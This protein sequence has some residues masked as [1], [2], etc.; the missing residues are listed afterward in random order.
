MQPADLSAAEQLIWHAFANGTWVDLR[1]GDPRLDDPRTA[2]RWPAS[3]TVRAK[4]IAALLLGAIEPEPGHLPAVRLRGVRITG[5]LDLMGATISCSLVCEYCQFDDAPRLTEAVTR[6]VRIVDSALPGLNAARLRADGIINLHRSVVRG[7][8]ILDRARVTGELFLRNVT[9]G[10]IPARADQSPGAG[11]AAGVALAAD[12]LVVDGDVDI[13]GATC[14]G[15]VR[16]R[17]AR[18]SGWMNASG[19]RF[20][21]AD[22]PALDAD[23]AVIGGSFTGRQLTSTGR[24]KFQHARIGGHLQLVGARL[25]CAGDW[26]LAAG[27]VTVDGGVW[28]SEG[29]TA[30]GEI[31]LIGATL[32]SNLTLAGALLAN[33]G[34]TALNLDSALLG[35]LDGAGLVVSAGQLRLVGT[36]VSGRVKL[37]GAEFSGSE[38]KPALIA[39]GLTVGKSLGLGGIRVSGE[40][41]AYG[42]RVGG[43]IVLSGASVV[44]PG[45]TALNLA[46]AEATDLLCDDMSA[47]GTVLLTGATV[48]RQLRMA[49]VRLTSQGSIALDARAIRALELSLLPAEPITGDVLLS[50][51]RLGMLRDDQAGRSSPVQLDGLVYDVLAPQLPAR[52][53]LRWLTDG[54][55]GHQPQPFEQLAALYTSIGQ[56]AEARRVLYAKERHQRTAKNAAGRLWSMI[57][58]VTVGYGFQPWRAAA[59]FAALLAVGSVV[60]AVSPPHV[61][62]PGTAP[63]FNP[64]AYSL[65]LLL[66]LVDLGQK[67]AVDPAGADQWFS[68]LLIAAGW[69]L[70]TAIAAAAA[71]IIRRQ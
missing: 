71:R 9:I 59:W 13:S 63:H 39:D 42:S 61:L 50:H 3:R 29:F 56:P 40:V 44:N 47:V 24:I 66:P 65:D 45:G 33:P 17:G 20:G 1:C 11:P 7:L 62:S 15:S 37:D 49:R 69:I 6:T 35:D 60:F 57:Q 25:R 52:H 12:G 26:A 68:Y 19:T 28:C 32:K 41:S 48:G 38:G 14:L 5:R 54:M 4:V 55:S 30:D 53:R 46:Q 22:G 64:V 8:L 16:L 21:C 34:G 31:R 18:V 36:Q 2:R 70:A 43:R 10:E 67:H 23:N 58:D 27:G 51:S